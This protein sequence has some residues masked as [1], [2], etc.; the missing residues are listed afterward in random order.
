MAVT[1]SAGVRQSLSALQSAASQQST[2]QN[3]L[4]TGKKVNSALD[5]PANF[6]TASGLSN[7]ANDLNRLLDDMG[8]SVKTLQAADKGLTA[9]GKLIENAQSIAKQARAFKIDASTATGSAST[10]I[11]ST[12]QLDGASPGLGFTAAKKITLTVGTGSGAKSVYHTVAAGDSVDDLIQTFNGVDGTNVTASVV[13]GQLQISDKNGR[14]IAVTTDDAASTLTALMG[15][16]TTADASED[17]RVTLQS[18]YDSL[19]S[20][21][22]QLAKDSSYNGV[23][24]LDSDKL[25]VQFNENGSSKLDITGTDVSSSGLSI[26]TSK[27][28]TDTNID[29]ALKSLKAA[30]DTIRS[31]SSSF[32]SNLSVVQ[33]RQDFTKGMIDTLQAGSD[34]LVIA[35]P[36]EEGANLLALNT[37]AQIAQTTLSMASQ[38]DSAVLRMF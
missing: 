3:R 21:I 28:D 31:Q 11:S 9:I 30:T 5:N 37:R 22:D 1:L 7:R 20:Q 2:I 6:F 12:T 16:T 17:K 19:M 26:D 4:A 29:A 25:S 18:D 32:G 15:S 33:N 34:A 36:N 23:N 24:L 35:D 10:A 8:Q 13:N 14:D 27:L 38:S